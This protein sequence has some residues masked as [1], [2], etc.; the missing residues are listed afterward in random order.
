[1]KCIYLVIVFECYEP[2]VRVFVCACACVCNIQLT[3]CSF[4]AGQ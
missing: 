3:R 4:E 2:A 1:M